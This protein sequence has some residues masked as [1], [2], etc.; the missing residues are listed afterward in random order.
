M[1]MKATCIVHFPQGSVDHRPLSTLRPSSTCH[2][3]NEPPYSLALSP[4]DHGLPS[5]GCHTSIKRGPLPQYSAWPTFF[6][7]RYRAY[8]WIKP[9]CQSQFRTVNI[10]T[11]RITCYFVQPS[12]VGWKASLIIAGLHD[13]K[14]Q[15]LCIKRH[16]GLMCMYLSSFSFAMVDLFDKLIGLGISMIYN[17]DFI[18]FRCINHLAVLL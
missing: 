7:Q 6:V 5:T 1:T 4:G 13:Q 18:L 8:D 15:C 14:F 9:Y 3:D 10:M 16:T 17:L 2:H 11:T 12:D